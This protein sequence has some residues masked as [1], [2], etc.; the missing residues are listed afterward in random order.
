MFVAWIYDLQKKFRPIFLRCD[1][2]HD[3]ERTKLPRRRQR[4]VE[5]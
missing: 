4:F 2:L 3:R 5:L 1:V